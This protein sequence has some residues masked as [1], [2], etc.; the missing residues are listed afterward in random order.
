MPIRIT[1]QVGVESVVK[2]NS[3]SLWQIQ[4]YK[5]IQVKGIDYSNALIK[6]L[7]LEVHPMR[8]KCCKPWLP[9]LQLNFTFFCLKCSDTFTIKSTR[10]SFKWQREQNSWSSTE[11]CTK[12]LL[13]LLIISRVTCP[14]LFCFQCLSSL[15]SKVAQML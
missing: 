3:F 7:K 9:S 5:K 11:S 6:N 13:V 4:T 15:T 8:I 10:G 12:E 14:K 2:N 1:C